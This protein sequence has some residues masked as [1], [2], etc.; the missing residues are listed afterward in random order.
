MALSIKQIITGTKVEG[1]SLEKVV[2]DDGNY[3][4]AEYKNWQFTIYVHAVAHMDRRQW[5]ETL[6][7]FVTAVMQNAPTENMTYLGDLDDL[8]PVEPAP[9]A[10]KAT[11]RADGGI[12]FYV[13]R[14]RVASFPAYGSEAE[15]FL[16][17][18][19]GKAP[20]HVRIKG[21]GEQVI[22]KGPAAEASLLVADT[23]ATLVGMGKA[24]API[25]IKEPEA[26][27][28]WGTSS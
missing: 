18:H 16:A 26:L 22:A 3:F 12:A 23:V 19:F 11:V 28:G 5:I 6:L 1:L 17:D 10:V 14:E 4:V 25:V 8:A 27:L 20:W 24:R 13:R 15:A 9:L 21:A 2:S 7:G